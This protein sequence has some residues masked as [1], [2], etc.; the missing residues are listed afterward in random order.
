VV[1]VLFTFYIQGVLKFK[2]N[3][4]PKGSITDCRSSLQLRRSVL[5]KYRLV[6]VSIAVPCRGNLCRVGI[7]S[8]HA[9]SSQQIGMRSQLQTPAA[10]PPR[11]E[12]PHELLQAHSNCN[13]D[14]SLFTGSVTSVRVPAA[15]LLTTSIYIATCD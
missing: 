13:A 12:L 4:P 5:E 15:A 1:P 8:T 10:L 9:L 11:N 7:T 6:P 3:P 2:N 14:H